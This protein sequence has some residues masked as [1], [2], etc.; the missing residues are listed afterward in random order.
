MPP[1]TIVSGAVLCSTVCGTVCST[2]FSTVFGIMRLYV[3]YC[4]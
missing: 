2:V 1:V 4:V 3:E